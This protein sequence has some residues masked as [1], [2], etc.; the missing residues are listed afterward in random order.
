MPDC[1]NSRFCIIL[2]M[3]ASGCAS[4]DARVEPVDET[5]MMPLGEGGPVGQKVP[6][7]NVPGSELPP[8]EGGSSGVAAGGVGGVGDV[9]GIL[10]GLVGG[11]LGG[12]G[13]TPRDAGA[14]VDAGT[15]SP[16]ADASVPDDPDAGARAPDEHAGKRLSAAH[17]REIA[18][19]QTVKSTLEVAGSKRVSEV[20]LLANRESYL[21]VYVQPNGPARSLTATLT[22]RASDGT[23][24]VTWAATKSVGAASS[25]ADV[26]S[27]FNFHVPADKLPDGVE[28]SVKLTEPSSEPVAD[29]VVHA[30]RYPADGSSEKIDV[31]DPEALKIVFV[32]V[33]VNGLAP[34]T[35]AEQMAGYQAAIL[36]MM[37]VNKVQIT[38]RASLNWN[39]QVTRDS[40]WDAL[41]T[42]LAAVRAA[43][44]AP[45]DVYYWG[46]LTPTN[47][48]ASFC[49]NSCINGLSYQSP[50]ASNASARVSLGTGY[51]GDDRAISQ[52]VMIHELGHAHGQV[53]TPCGGTQQNNAS[54]PYAGGS[55]GVWGYDPRAQLLICPSESFDIMSYC[56]PF[57]MSDYTYE[58]MYT[59]SLAVNALGGW[60]GGAAEERDY[61]LATVAQNGA[62]WGDG[63]RTSQP[64]GEPRTVQFR[65]RGVVVATDIAYVAA[66]DHVHGASVAVPGVQV[67]YTE[68]EVEGVGTFAA[69][70]R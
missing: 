11:I 33:V 62:D 52:E 47:D 69:A 57:W 36:A 31:I 56:K 37:P 7:D 27:T 35:S 30:A 54:Y 32:P 1:S 58:A 12:L 38:M 19:Y 46:A 9:G 44:K 10:G 25:D 50:Q 24:L 15:P 28:Y 17:V 45:S 40:G 67:P 34:D 49:Q 68:V 60:S 65:Y 70:S 13:G 29:G 16:A 42:K 26:R 22:L 66:F 51:G 21:R 2:S 64:P 55:V 20:P 3:L 59:R 5:G 14:A 23:E 43:D 63:M 6:F 61:R 4:P 8:A 39:Q 48:F 18:L 53:H 41:L